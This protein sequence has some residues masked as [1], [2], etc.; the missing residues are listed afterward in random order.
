[1]AENAGFGASALDGEMNNSLEELEKECA[2]PGLPGSAPNTP[3]SAVGSEAARA[4]YDVLRN[5]E[6]HLTFTSAPSKNYRV[7]A[8]HGATGVD[9]KNGKLAGEY[10]KAWAEKIKLAHAA[11]ED[12]AQP[13]YQVLPVTEQVD[14]TRKSGGGIVG[15]S[16]SGMG[17]VQ[18]KKDMDEEGSFQDKC[19]LLEAFGGKLDS[20]GVGVHLIPEDLA[21]CNF[22]VKVDKGMN[23]APIFA[24]TYMIYK[25]FGDSD[26][27]LHDFHMGHMY[28]TGEGVPVGGDAFKNKQAIG[29]NVP[30]EAKLIAM[31]ERA[32]VAMAQSDEKPWLTVVEDAS[33]TKRLK[34][35][36][37][38]G[39]MMMAKLE[40]GMFR[41][42]GLR[43]NAEE[44]FVQSMDDFIV[45]KRVF[46]KGTGLVRGDYTVG[47]RGAELMEIVFNSQ[48]DE[49]WL[50]GVE[51]VGTGAG[52]VD[53]RGSGIECVEIQYRLQYKS[54]FLFALAEVDQMSGDPSIGGVIVREECTGTITTMQ[55][56]VDGIVG[57]AQV[58]AEWEG[59]GQR[60]H[61]NRA[62]ENRRGGSAAVI[63][64]GDDAGREGPAHPRTLE[65]DFVRALD[66]ASTQQPGA[67]SPTQGDC[68][69][70]G[71]HEVL[72]A[73]GAA[74]GTLTHSRAD[75]QGADGRLR[76]LWVR[77]RVAGVG[78]CTA[79]EQEAA[80]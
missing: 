19:S 67:R 9:I 57:G 78:M 39:D 8:V 2:T 50:V 43:F 29:F 24:Q 66:E 4:E 36:K 46:S 7:V 28:D 23:L 59:G 62:A 18:G 33:K 80:G 25:N 45:K 3:S 68:T 12:R 32:A 48:S 51:A 71:G 27:I 76:G 72:L 70:G 69:D 52:G 6:P 11:L 54:E 41:Y 16:Y 15:R 65:E 49:R 17:R 31:F 42:Y 58:D 1:M 5:L 73:H 64:R 26:D 60:R 47:A 22:Y 53:L 34:V 38:G 40:P 79:A 13:I 77:R 20:D 30:S 10:A 63:L 74:N 55:I 75:R 44:I 37:N 61:D 21:G 14:Y 56:S 35:D